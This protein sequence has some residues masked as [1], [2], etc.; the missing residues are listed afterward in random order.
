MEI[1]AVQ[2]NWPQPASV[3]PRI[4]DCE[5]GLDIP[6]SEQHHYDGDAK[7]IDD[8]DGDRDGADIDD[9]VG[10]GDDSDVDHSDD[11]YIDEEMRNTR[12]SSTWRAAFDFIVL[13][14]RKR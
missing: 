4:R 7:N 8:G 14:E 2:G 6:H 12:L 3:P 10:D 9:G 1:M 11:A 13:K 5:A